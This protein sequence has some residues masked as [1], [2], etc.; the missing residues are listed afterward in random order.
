MQGIAGQAGAGCMH[1]KMSLVLHCCPSLIFSPFFLLLL[2]G[3]LLHF[4]YL[5]CLG[6]L[7]FLVAMETMCIEDNGL[8]VVIL[9]QAP[10]LQYGG[11]YLCMG[12]TK[13]DIEHASAGLT[14]IMP[15]PVQSASKKLTVSSVN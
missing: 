11:P 8:Y 5:P 1:F 3:C 14:Q 9:L 15:Y 2:C 13:L 10:N 4:W 12:Q 6:F 7:F